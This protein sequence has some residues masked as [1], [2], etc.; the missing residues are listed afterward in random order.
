[1]FVNVESVLTSISIIELIGKRVLIISATLLSIEE[2]RQKEHDADFL[3][4]MRV[5][6]PL[7]PA[8][9]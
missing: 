7:S 3:L 2:A 4:K 9:N 1:M 6:H 8:G 5:N